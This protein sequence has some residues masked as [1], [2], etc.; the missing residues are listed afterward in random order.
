M[1]AGRSG[2]DCGSCRKN[3]LEEKRRCGFLPPERRG[4]PRIVWGRGQVHTEECPKS[5]ITGESLTL[6]E[7][8]LVR[9]RM[10]ISE[11]TETEAR[12]MDGFLVLR[13]QIE[14]EERDDTSEY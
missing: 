2:W 14:Q 3:G 11:S 8:F 9:R 12:R 13:E 6:L 5:M 1:P 4:A 10:G 7:E